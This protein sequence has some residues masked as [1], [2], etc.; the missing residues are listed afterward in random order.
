MPSVT[1]GNPPF[2]VSLAMSDDPSAEGEREVEISDS[3][4]DSSIS[5]QNVGGSGY[6]PNSPPPAVKPRLDPLVAS[7]TRMDPE[8]AGAETTNVPLIGEIPKD[9]SIVPLG[10]A[11]S[12]AVIGF[13]FSI[14]IALSSKDAILAEMKETTDVMS[15]PPVMK[16]VPS[17]DDGCRGLCGSQ[18]Q[19][20]DNLRGI[21]GKLAK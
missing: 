17:K 8:T 7:L 5:S 18:E 2:P 21:M 3:N 11:A 4:D 20:L 9:G 10:A 15:A 13:I 1:I 14:N 12:I 16:T 19:D 6:I